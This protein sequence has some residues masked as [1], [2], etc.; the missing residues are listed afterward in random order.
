MQ[1]F[2]S[3]FIPVARAANIV[4]AP[5]NLITSTSAIAD[6]FCRALDWMFWFFIVFSIAMALVAAYLYAS[7]NGDPERVHKASKT[8]LYVAIAIVVALL[9]KGIPLIVSSFIGGG[10]DNNVCSSGSTP[11]V[12][13]TFIPL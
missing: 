2:L 7:S 9:A 1:Y 6:L 8:L 13:S 4:S 11:V 12:T 5:T 3:L 10:F